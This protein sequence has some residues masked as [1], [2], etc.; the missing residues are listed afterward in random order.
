MFPARTLTKIRRIV[1]D[2]SLFVG[3]GVWVYYS[4][5]NIESLF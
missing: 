1:S 3:V 4:M 5:S 2:S